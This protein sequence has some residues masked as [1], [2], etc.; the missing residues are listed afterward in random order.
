[1]HADSSRHFRAVI[2]SIATLFVLT[3]FSFRIEA[4]ASIS[5][6]SIVMAMLAV[7]ATTSAWLLYS[8]AHPV[9]PLPTTSAPTAPL[10]Y[11]PERDRLTKAGTAAQTSS[12]PHKSSAKFIET[13]TQTEVRKIPT[14]ARQLTAIR[15]D[16]LPIRPELPDTHPPATIVGV[17]HHRPAPIQRVSTSD[18]AAQETSGRRVA[19]RPLPRSP[20]SPIQI[21]APRP[22][23]PFPN[24]GLL[25]QPSVQR[26]QA[27][28][29]I[30]HRHH[31]PPVQSQTHNSQIQHPYVHSSRL[32]ELR[33]LHLTPIKTDLPARSAFWVSA[34]LLSHRTAAEPI[35]YA[36]AGYEVDDGYSPDTN[37]ASDCSPPPKGWSLEPQDVAHKTRGNRRRR[38]RKA[39]QQSRNESLD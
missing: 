20:A 8:K 30:E 16:S 12:V 35:A 10:P 1:M 18:A 24:L 14:V 7:V 37:H 23:R 5:G 19:S 21:H 6:E 39:R 31:T 29:S 15:R 2:T 36:L 13:V 3:M 34:T 17:S 27:A 38:W 26:V 22:L 25:H 9:V 11:H 33:R 28:N 32:N 4:E